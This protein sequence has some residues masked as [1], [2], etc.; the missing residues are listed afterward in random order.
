MCLKEEG[1]AEK[2]LSSRYKVDKEGQVSVCVASSVEFLGGESLA[3]GGDVMQRGLYGQT[4]PTDGKM[5]EGGR[6]KL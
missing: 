5:R 4:L 2:C 3:C 6:T 1:P